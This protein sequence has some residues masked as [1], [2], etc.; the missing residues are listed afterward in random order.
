MPKIRPK[1]Q[2]VK[3]GRPVLK[4]KADEQDGLCGICLREAAVIPP[5][6]FG[7][8]HDLAERLVSLNEVPLAYREIAWR[9]GV[10]FLAG[11]IDSISERN[12][13]YLK[14]SPK[15]LAF[16]DQCRDD[17][18]VPSE[19]SLSD[20]DR[21]KQQIYEAKIKNAERLP[22]SLYLNKITICSMPL[23]AIS[24]AQR[25]WPGEDD[26]TIILTPDE[27][28]KW[29]TIYSHPKDAFWWFIDYW[30]NIDDSPKQKF[31]VGDITFFNWNENEVPEGNSPWLVNSGLRWG[32]LYGGGS[33]EL[34]LWDGKHCK[35]ARLKDN[36]N[37]NVT[38]NT[39]II[40]ES[41]KNGV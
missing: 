21:A 13:L 18:P 33:T 4:S 41:D 17:Q 25:L 10:D 20:S 1:T 27:Q 35:F 40:S 8:P 36:S 37:F 24:V 19:N 5:D 39:R 12:V 23:V 15:L 14:W 3:C 28:S 30:W 16:A 32:P 22:Q 2:C 31:S 26:S 11:Y 9:E 34:W 38:V 6:D 7:M 29:H